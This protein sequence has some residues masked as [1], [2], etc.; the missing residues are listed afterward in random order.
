MVLGTM[1]KNKAGKEVEHVWGRGDPL[2][3]GVV[4]FLARKWH[5]RGWLE[6]VERCGDP[7]DDIIHMYI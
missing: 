4:T 6:E 3:G 7:K 1:R 5:L 2:G